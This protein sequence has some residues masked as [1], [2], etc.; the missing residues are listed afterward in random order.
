VPSEVGIQQDAVASEIA[1]QSLVEIEEI[2]P[3][4]KGCRVRF[5]TVTDLETGVETPIPLE[6]SREGSGGVLFPKE[7]RGF[8]VWPHHDL[9]GN[10]PGSRYHTLLFKH[11]LPVDPLSPALPCPSGGKAGVLCPEVER[12]GS[13]RG[14]LNPGVPEGQGTS[15]G[16]F[17]LPREGG[18]PQLEVD[19]KPRALDL[20][21][22]TGS[23]ASRLR[24]LGYEVITLDKNPR[25]GAQI[26]Q[27][28][29]HWRY[30][31][32]PK[33]YFKLIA[34]SI[35]CNEY[36]VAKS[37]GDRDL[38]L[39]D[40][41]ARKTLEIIRYFQPEIWWIENPRFGMLRHR[42]FMK[43]LPF[44]DVDY[45]QFSSW[46]YKKPTRIW[47]SSSVVNR[48]GRLCDWWNCPNVEPW[49][50]GVWRHRRVLGGR[51]FQTATWWK[52][53]VP[54]ALVDY[55]LNCEQNAPPLPREVVAG[56]YQAKL[57][58]ERHVE[59]AT[60][61]VQDVGVFQAGQIRNCGNK[62]QLLM[63]IQVEL[64]NGVVQKLDI[65][66]DTGAEANLVKLN[67]LP[68]HLTYAAGRPL[69]FVTAS[70]QHLDGGAT[71]VDL[72]L[73]FMQVVAGEVL[74]DLLRREATFYEA[75]IKVDA[76]LSYPWMSKNR[77]GV[78]PHL[79]AM[80]LEEPELI[81]LYGTTPEAYKG[82]Q[83]LRSKSPEKGCPRTRSG[84]DKTPIPKN[85][86]AVEVS[87]EE[88]LLVADGDQESQF[89]KL[90]KLGLAVYHPLEP[91]CL[92]FLDNSEMEV[93]HARLFHGGTARRIRRLIK[94]GDDPPQEEA[95]E[96]LRKKIIQDY[97]GTV[98]RD[99]LIPGLHERGMFG[100]AY[101]PLKEGAMPTRQKPI[102]AHGEKQE[103]Y[104]KIV[105]DW[106]EKGFIERPWKK[107]IE[108]S[109]AGFA[110]PKKSVDFPWRGVVD[111][112]GP[113]SQMLKCN[114]PLPCIEDILVR[115]GANQMFSILDLK[116]AF[117]Q[118]PLHPESRHITCT[119]TPK[120][121]YQWRVN[122]MG[123]KNAGIQFQ[124]MM[125]DRMQTVK[126][127]A[128][129]YIDD[130]LV[131]SREV[132][133]ED[134]LVTHD[135][136]LRRVMDVLKAELLV[137]DPKKCKFFVREVEFCGH[138]L[139]GGTRRPAPGKLS[140]IEKWEVPKTIHELRAFLGFTNY[141]SI[142]IKDYAK[143]VS[144]LQDKLKV[145]REEGK[146]GSKKKIFWEQED[147]VA[148][149]E[150]KAR[151]CSQ[152]VLQR[153]NPDK[154]FILRADASQYAIGAT[155]EQL[156]DEDRF[157]TAEDVRNQKTVPVAFMSRK[158]TQS[159]RNWVPRE[160]ETYA[161]I[162]ALE[163][164]ESWIGLQPVLILT[165]HQALQHWAK[166]VLDTPSGPVGR[167]S[168]W[169]QI[170]SR[171]DLE[172]GYVPGKENT[173]A[174]VLSRWAYPAG[175]VYRDMCKHGNA[176]DKAEVEEIDR[177]EK[178][179]AR[180]CMAVHKNG[181]MGD[182]SSEL[183][184]AHMRP[185]RRKKGREPETPPSQF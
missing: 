140:A 27:D 157:P 63:N 148:F 115:Q 176:E 170:L 149:E 31:K 99:T 79:E 125:D 156:I 102:V 154:P 50:D 72:T 32:F 89:L 95:V 3:I 171:F 109:S 70:G 38:E 10:A 61:L 53:R 126:D 93:I 68:R 41:I 100:Y 106:L 47:G 172:V 34:A 33:K 128:D 19:S 46:G 42:P 96:E 80:A 155:L 11:P 59:V 24:D 5:G 175:Q 26:Q 69:K 118:Q 134:I 153:V 35:P 12:A 66:V 120:G 110:V 17:F 166:E 55:M 40:T 74:P 77:I 151:L 45:C 145:P 51:Y 57:E 62:W 142:Y 147:T 132:D 36:S 71:C 144:R 146:K 161:I 75:D 29:L 113:N 20:F 135:R 136:D 15:E 22:G 7:W 30:R 13:A 152:L 28:I 78:F 133:G 60:R 81:L 14:T 56:P 180:E 112:R 131:G 130:I 185:V 73:E 108:W 94:A 44:M 123:L 98:L 58:R 48:G 119:H 178:E 65:L 23:V 164:W 182:D 49:S 124:Q 104:A 67:R 162:V 97:E 160:Q 127:V 43:G 168:R 173:V 6:K 37:V 158:L 21:S 122:V 76:I 139:G 85:T 52:G 163:K 141:Y 83:K 18:T 167:R 88:D 179:D 181:E 183:G 107:G 174:D 165:D 150:I 101:I 25:A 177:Q 103:A 116:Q 184:G 90:A 84:P 87:E 169:H 159:Q 137:A 92:D 129:P 138:I 8:V 117:H 111:L 82:A 64:S 2:L 54:A 114:Y 16:F 39:A 86:C 105:E 4:G 9:G 121:I 1:L 143:V 91:L